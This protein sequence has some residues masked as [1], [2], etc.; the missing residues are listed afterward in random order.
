M[1]RCA[2]GHCRT[3]IA[4][5]VLASWAAGCSSDGSTDAPPTTDRPPTT[6]PTP[7]MV[8]LGLRTLPSCR[9][10]E[11]MMRESALQAMNRIIDQSL[12]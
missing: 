11:A 7:A 8:G 10:V 1:G 12:A 6:E 4:A 5:L 9:D 2:G 3:W